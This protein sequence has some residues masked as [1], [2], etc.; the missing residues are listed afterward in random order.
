MRKSSLLNNN[1]KRKLMARKTIRVK[2]PTANPMNS[3]NFLTR[4]MNNT[5][6]WEKTAH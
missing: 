1:L 5:K 2:M 3:A 4:L 6:S